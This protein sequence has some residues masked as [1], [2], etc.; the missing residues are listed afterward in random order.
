MNVPARLDHLV[1]A[2]DNLEAA[3]N[4][5][6][7]LTSV[8][9]VLGGSHPGFGTHNALLSLGDGVYLELVAPDPAQSAPSQ[10][11]WT[12]TAPQGGGL[13]TWALRGDDLAALAHLAREA[14]GTIGEV[15]PARR[16]QP[17]GSLLTWTL[18]NPF[19]MPFGGAVPFLIDWGSSPHPSQ[20][21]PLA[22]T[23]TGFAIEH[24][25]ASALAEVFAAMGEDV[26]ITE[27]PQFRIKAM[28]ACQH[29]HVE[30]S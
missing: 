17:D 2:S 29:G 1:Y 26:T 16:S 21:A 4:Q 3:I 11:L 30:I 22:G 24:P 27:A 12:D 15:F 13:M 25:Q 28:I 8:R 9:A 19:A 14:G 10:G 7:E 5:L 20:S 23:L 18:T 6:E